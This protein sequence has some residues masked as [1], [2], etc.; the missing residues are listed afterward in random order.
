MKL[1]KIEVLK[2]DRN[3]YRLFMIILKNKN[4]NKKRYPKIKK[5]KKHILNK[6]VFLIKFYLYK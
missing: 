3:F 4:T 6:Y 2:K 5:Y 1:L